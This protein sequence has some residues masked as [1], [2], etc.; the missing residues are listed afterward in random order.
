MG[1]L[2]PAPGAARRR[3]T[4]LGLALTCAVTL[5]P[6]APG[7]AA[8]DPDQRRKSAVD[9]RIAST[10]H[11]LEE[12]SAQFQRAYDALGA[13]NARLP[14]ARAAAADAEAARAAAD[15]REAE[16]TAALELAKATEAKA[17]Q[18][19]AATRKRLAA[20]EN[21]VRDLA[22]QMYM[23]TGGG[24]LAV[25]LGSSS[26][27]DFADRVALVD[28]VAGVQQSRLDRLATDRASQSAQEAQLSALRAQ[29]AKAQADARA[30][31][32][33]ATRARDAAASARTA[34]ET[35]A[36]AQQTQTVALRDQHAAEMTRLSS[37][38]AESDRL[39]KVLVERARQAKIRAEIAR[40]ERERRARILA[41]KRK[42]PYVPPPADT[43]DGSGFLSSAMP[44]WAI[45]SEFGMRFHPILH[46]WKLHT[47]MD[48]GAPCGTP[49]YAAGPGTIIMSGWAGGYGN[50]VVIDHGIVNGVNLVSTYNHMSRIADWGGSVR[51]GQLIG[52]EG[53]TG[54]STGCHLHFE[55]LVDGRFDNPRNWL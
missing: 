32:A 4:A 12:T 30:A 13:T 20:S 2:N 24:Q 35:L 42:K 34:L 1:R 7:H 18:A 33:R 53:T 28:Q 38:Q 48:F 3:L 25:A 16:A 26:P 14:G 55:T 36:R 15:E 47:G 11:D 17:E 50:R 19:L 43:V 49:V 39:Q 5:L 10:R 52:Y 6:G 27:S 45:T 22:A 41:A 44:G 8:T 31:L 37:L 46:Y 29:S 54:M 40:R 21:D 23:Q 9:D 51:R